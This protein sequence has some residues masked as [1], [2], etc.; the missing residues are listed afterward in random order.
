MSRLEFLILVL[1]TSN[2]FDLLIWFTFF[3]VLFSSTLTVY[4]DH[5][6]LMPLGSLCSTGLSAL[7]LKFIF[8][9][10]KS[11]SSS[12]EK[13]MFSE[14]HSF[15]VIFLCNYEAVNLR[16]HVVALLASVIVSWPA[17]TTKKF[18]ASRIDLLLLVRQNSNSFDLNAF[19]SN[20]VL[21]TSYF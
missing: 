7:G 19:F 15:F 13:L 2:R 20:F 17:K 11:S 12:F 3:K 6:Q 5:V 9:L 14:G 16:L 1:L 18:N 4:E 8:F 10:L 21:F